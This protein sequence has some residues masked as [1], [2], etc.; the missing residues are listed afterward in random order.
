MPGLMS[1]YQKRSIKIAPYLF[2][3]PNILLFLVFMIFPILFTFYISFHKWTILG[4]PDFVGLGNYYQLLTDNVFWISLWNTLYYTL[5]TVPFSMALGLA[6]AILLNRKI[7]LR[8]FFRGV[9]FAPVVVSLVATGLIWSWMYNPNYGL[10]NHLL[11]FVGIEGVNWLSS[12]TWAMPAVI[13]TTLWV[14]TGYCLVI[15]LAGLQAIP[16]SLYEAAEIDG[17]NAWQK[18]WYV[19]LPLLK[20]TTT[21]VLVISVI[22]GFMVFDLIYTMTNGGPGHSTT[23]IVQY[24]YQKAFVEGDM[25]YGSALGAVLFLIMMV[26]VAIQLRLGREKG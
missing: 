7:P 3:A 5:G 25:G 20:H 2:I 12:T 8:A 24:I 10:F 16:E 11:Q 4:K 13:I 15:Y 6:G 14:R 19:T 18:F 17:A 26:L 1:W 23:V 22:Y 21:F 9:F